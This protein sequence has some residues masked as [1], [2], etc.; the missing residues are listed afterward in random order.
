MTYNIH[1]WAGQDRRVDVERLAD[2]I[3]STGAD[4]VALNEVLHPV[5]ES[6][7]IYEPLSE[8]AASLGMA[9]AFGPS[10]WTDFGPGWR[11]LV[12]NALLSRY[13]LSAVTNT[14]LPRSPGSKQRSLLGA[15]LGAGAAQGLYAYVTHLDHASEG[16]RLLQIEGALTHLSLQQPHFLAGD[17]NTH[18]FMGRRS[19]LLLAPVLRRM[20]GAG[21]QDAFYAVGTGAGR[22]FPALSPLLRLDFLFMPR[23]WALGLRSA[24]TVQHDC[25]STA[26][27]HLPMVVE[28]GWPPPVYAIEAGAHGPTK[29]R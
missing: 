4:V 26:S 20:R 16:T 9:F 25:I 1:R 23:V 29:L 19:R 6:H 14:W 3:R 28:W 7:R 17:F 21:Y 27:G 22:T 18:G 11:G 8:L 13:P 12:G 5:A 10:G 24:G 15:R 2:V